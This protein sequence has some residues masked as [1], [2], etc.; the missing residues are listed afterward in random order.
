MTWG[1]VLVA[2]IGAC[3]AVGP[4]QKIDARTLPK[5]IR[6]ICEATGYSRNVRS[7]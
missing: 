3:C 6:E 7:D 1:D 2:A 4:D 5:D